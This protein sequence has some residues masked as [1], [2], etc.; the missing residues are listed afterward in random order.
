MELTSHELAKRFLNYKDSPIK[1]VTKEGAFY[2]NA[3][4]GI[5]NT[6]YLL[7]TREAF[8]KWGEALEG[9]PVILK[10]MIESMEVVIKKAK[11]Y[12]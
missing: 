4:K 2:V 5:H 6:I 3:A 1:V 10:D 12:L 11:A 9:Q 7:T 8:D